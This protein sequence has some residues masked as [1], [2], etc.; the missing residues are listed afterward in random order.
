MAGSPTTSKHDF[1]MDT[2]EVSQTDAN[3][4]MPE[5]LVPPGEDDEV[6]LEDG[7]VTKMT[8]EKT[9]E[10]VLVCDITEIGMSYVTDQKNVKEMG[11]QPTLNF[12]S[13][14]FPNIDAILVPGA[15]NKGFM[16]SMTIS[17]SHS[18][19]QEKAVRLLQKS[20][21]DN[22]NMPFLFF[23]PES[24]FDNFKYQMP[25]GVK[26]RKSQ[27]TLIIPQYVVKVGQ[28]E[29]EESA[30]ILESLFDSFA[31]D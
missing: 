14:S 20:G 18:F 24:V 26:D 27:I 15:N 7:D 3:D 22:S 5:E 9:N 2:A 1:F 19:R 4:L 21:C 11:L 6:I 8:S 17:S 30:Q 28:G 31:K 13:K 16:A 23:V 25:A 12:T 10:E 29:F